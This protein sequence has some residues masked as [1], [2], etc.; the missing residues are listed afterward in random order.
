MNFAGH[1]KTI[2]KHKMLVMQGCFQV[3]LFGQGLLHDLSK[4]S[5]IEF[6]TGGWYFQ[7]TRSPNAAERDKKGYSDAWLHHKGRNKHHYEYWI[8][9]NPKDPKAPLRI[10]PMPDRYIIEMFMDR[11][12]ACKVYNGEAFTQ[13][14][15]LNY[16][17]LG[18]TAQFLHPHTQ[19]VLEG[20]LKMYA[21]KGE[22]YTFKYIRVR[23]LKNDKFLCFLEWICQT[24]EQLV[25]MGKNKVMKGSI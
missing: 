6:L 18:N 2:T 10:A 15:P 3:G 25:V 19:M 20:L 23:V 14:D 22:E 5:P 11:I 21:R 16:Y 17:N 7:G 24:A 8:D 9:F 4:Y 1:F 12:A 13:E